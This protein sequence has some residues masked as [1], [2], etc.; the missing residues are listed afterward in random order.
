MKISNIAVILIIE[1]PKLI[2]V[3]CKSTSNLGVFEKA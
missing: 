2:C 1:N 3:L